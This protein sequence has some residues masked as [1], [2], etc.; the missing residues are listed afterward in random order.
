M[1]ANSTFKFAVILGILANIAVLPVNAKVRTVSLT[2][3]SAE[4]IQAVIKRSVSNIAAAMT[5][6][7]EAVQTPP[8][9]HLRHRS[10][11]TPTIMATNAPTQSP[12]QSLSNNAPPPY[13]ESTV[14]YILYTSYS[15]N[16]DCSGPPDFVQASIAGVCTRNYD[17]T[18]PAPY[19]ISIPVA[20][21]GW[22]NTIS[23]YFQ[24]S[25]CT[26]TASQPG[27]DSNSFPL[28]SCLSNV[29]P[30]PGKS[31]LKIVLSD[32]P[33]VPARSGFLSTSYN[34]VEECLSDVSY[35]VSVTNAGCFYNDG[36]KAFQRYICTPG[37]SSYTLISYN[38]SSCKFQT[39]STSP[40]MTIPSR[41][42]LCAANN[43]Y[44]TCANVPSKSF[45]QLDVYASEA[46]C[47]AG[48]A[49]TIQSV[50]YTS[51]GQCNQNLFYDN[52]G[53][54][55]GVY[56]STIARAVIS[57]NKAITVVTQNYSDPFCAFKQGNP[58]SQTGLNLGCSASPDSTKKNTF[59]YRPTTTLP[60]LSSN[61]VY[62]FGYQSALACAAG[63]SNATLIATTPQC[64]INEDGQ[65]QSFKC[66]S[67]CGTKPTPDTID[68]YTYS[69][70]RCTK[71][72]TVF[73][74]YRHSCVLDTSPGSNDNSALYQSLSCV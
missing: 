4:E 17:Q 56:G 3:A 49:S 54:L 1:Q 10:L 53:K 9:V 32:T 33:P 41:S 57:A 6:D 5:P 19:V 63:P 35:P 34:S 45:T 64:E 59:I 25:A 67:T 27:I 13:T 38:D 74:D 73:K 40:V 26:I 47:L 69:D 61:K 48:V 31:S 72:V 55:T 7:V 30:Q 11:D 71:L 68:I 14:K 62:V 20:N 29:L 52:N 50:M 39:I 2:K 12:V 18:I 51:F 22:A 28:G 21:G 37:G 36:S 42:A 24:D 66:G 23:Q 16:S 46:A 60:K 70:R 8:E 15:S 43:N 65:Y 58:S 44:V